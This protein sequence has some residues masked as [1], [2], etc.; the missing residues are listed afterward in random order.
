MKVKGTRQM[1]TVYV[2]ENQKQKYRGILRFFDGFKSLLGFGFQNTKS[3]V[4]SALGSLKFSL[5]LRLSPP[6]GKAWA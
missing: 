6:S 3:D 4:A 2:E 1:G 5:T